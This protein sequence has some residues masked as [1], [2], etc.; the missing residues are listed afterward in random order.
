MIYRIN[1]FKKTILIYFFGLLLISTAFL[2]AQE[3]NA[4]FDHLT[5][6]EG[7]SNSLVLDM[8]QDSS[9]FVWIATQDGLNRFDGY[10]FKVFRGDDTITTVPD[11]WITS[12]TTDIKGNVWFGTRTA[13]LGKIDH[14]TNKFIHFKERMI[15]EFGDY[16]LNIQNLFITTENKLLMGTWGA[17]LL[18]YDIERSEFEQYLH[19]DDD[20][21]SISEN[22][23]YSVY[24]DSKGI[25]W[26]GAH[27]SGLNRLDKKTG[28]F[29]HIDFVSQDSDA[30]SNNF[31]LSILEDYTGDIWVGTYTSGLFKIIS[32]T[33]TIVKY[34]VRHKMTGITI[35]R[36]FEDSNKN[37]WICSANNGIYKYIRDENRFINYRNNPMISKSLNRDKVW[38]VFEDKTGLLWFGTSTNGINI[39]DHTKNNFKWIAHQRYNEN[40]ISSSYIK[41]IYLDGNNNLWL[42]TSE[43]ISIV[44]KSGSVQNINIKSGLSNNNIRK[45]YGD[46]RGKIWIAT[47]GGGVT[48]FD[49]L[50]RKFEYLKKDDGKN[51]L[52]DNYLR[53]IFEKGDKM[54]F[55][56]ERGLSEYDIKT[57][58]F[59]LY[60]PNKND[61]TTISYLQIS[62]IFVDSKNNFWIG[63]QRGLNLFNPEKGTFRRIEVKGSKDTPQ[64]YRIS[65]IFEDS[66]QRLW[67]GTNGA[68]FAQYNIET[69]EFM[70]IT[71]KEGL[72]NNAVYEIL[73][74]NSGS[75]WI[76]TNRGLNRF[77]PDTKEIKKYSSS[78]G[79]PGDE[80]NGGAAIK[81]TNGI[82]Y[83]GGVEGLIYFDPASLSLTQTVP[84]IVI[85]R[86]TINGKEL[87]PNGLYHNLQNIDLPYDSNFI[88]ISFSAMDFGKPES[89]DYMYKLD[90][91]NDDWISAENGNTAVFTNLDHGNYIF[92]VIGSNSDGIWNYNGRTI[93][94]S[95]A[96][97]WWDT[98]SART[99]Y[100]LL[101]LFT[102]YG[103][104]K[105]R[106][107]QIAERQLH[108]ERQVNE[109][110]RD[111]QQS[112]KLLE[113]A[114]AAKDKLFSIIAHDLKNPFVALLGY[115]E[116]LTKDSSHLSNDERKDSIQY[117]YDASR[118]VYS[119]L[120]NLLDWARLQLNNLECVPTKLDAKSL[121]D[122]VV[123]IYSTTASIKSVNLVNNIETGTI[124]FADENMSHTVFRNLISNSIKFTGKDGSINV[125][126]V[127]HGD[128]VEIIVKDTGIGMNAETL[129]RLKVNPGFNLSINGTAQEQGTG[130]GLMLVKEFIHMNNGNIIFSSEPGQGT[131]ISIFLPAGL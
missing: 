102:I 122:D 53:C 124:I 62:D 52:A 60:L 109:R 61:S 29:T 113:E 59:K 117:I 30:V 32:G 6:E 69:N 57:K 88:N 47:W 55:G 25:I 36:V 111:L 107:K 56:T 44:D 15:E 91:L 75:L 86:I 130:L 27:R 126:A 16:S 34:N 95:I 10:S 9:G 82:L 87:L 93:K 12:I 92:Y 1:P 97:P 121:I 67:I 14:K 115:S 77:Y 13:G 106:I 83:F 81:D 63:T 105:L 101:I 51:S 4:L 66:H 38:S 90:G 116:M 11:N 24:Q 118:S 114:V 46:R 119:L 17:G 108:L 23:I 120:Q 22:R 72:S 125:F 94:I 48:I 127:N 131:I 31:V 35:S 5:I 8:T 129:K 99:I 19:N 98:V 74:D 70:F 42:G 49:P 40:S 71:E 28:E 45:I 104:Y 33:G 39:F 123:S 110:T 21:N 43:G 96:P 20:I 37:L 7:L 41:S 128:I 54:Y 58:S 80:F 18:I 26:A 112:K 3:E 78:D 85:T 79:L 64:R 103:I 73:E 2:H 50:S 68:G 65:E 100:I 76:S 89:N 84:E